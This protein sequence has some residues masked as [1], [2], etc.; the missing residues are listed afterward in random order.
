MT[1]RLAV[2]LLLTFLW[3]SSEAAAGFISLQTTVTC[4]VTERG[5]KAE[6]SILNLGDEAATD[7]RVE[8]RCLDVSRVSP[9][10][11]RL[12]PGETWE[13]SIGLDPRPDRPG[14]YPVQILVDFHDHKGR[15]Y[16]ALS[17][18][19][20]AYEEGTTPMVFSEPVVLELKDKKRL[21]V[22]LINKDQAPHEVRLRLVLPRELAAAAP[23]QRLRLEAGERRE[24]SFEL[25]NRSALPGASYPV[26]AFIQYQSH[27]RNHLAVSENQARVARF[28]PFFKRYRFHLLVAAGLLM[29]AVL[30]L[31]LDQRRRLKPEQGD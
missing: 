1:G 25:E 27:G 11:R 24:V 5:V 3:L 30:G 19:S 22:P 23:E 4:A 21:T 12:E 2:G 7:L 17:Y 28:E 9:A 13:L 15:L 16:T 14:A 20:F 31:E 18:S 8:A 29:L 6:V 26:L 10:R